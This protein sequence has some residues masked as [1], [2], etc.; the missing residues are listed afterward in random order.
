METM[1]K[2][3]ILPITEANV[4]DW[5]SL[6]ADQSSDMQHTIA[7]KLSGM[8]SLRLFLVKSGQRVLARFGAKI[9]N[10]VLELW[11]P[12]LVD[13]LNAHQGQAIYEAVLEAGKRLGRDEGAI[14]VEHSFKQAPSANLNPWAARLGAS[15]FSWVATRRVWCANLSQS[16][17]LISDGIAVSGRPSLYTYQSEDSIDQSLLSQL[18]A[19]TGDRLDALHLAHGLVFSEGDIHTTVR[20]G[21]EI[22]AVA[23]QSEPSLNGKVWNTF[24]GVLPSK[25]GKGIG[26]N[27]LSHQ[28]QGQKAA[29][30]SQSLSIID[31]NNPASERIHAKLGF[32]TE[33]LVIR[34][35]VYRC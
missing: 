8:P 33:Q 30:R 32:V 34:S 11:Q 22:I 2:L 5:L 24:I 1:T 16:D 4:K 15:N 27:L 23:S 21:R 18:Q 17:S 28:L 31:V 12:S 10:Q 6:E 7:H 29:G 14:F 25:R 3:D 19:D 13:G 9:G 26:F 20:R 35:F